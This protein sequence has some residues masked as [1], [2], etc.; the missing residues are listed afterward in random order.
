MISTVSAQ[1]S[2][3]LLPHDPETDFGIHQNV[4]NTGA[5]VCKVPFQ[6]N[7]VTLSVMVWDGENPGLGWD[8][9][10][11]S[12]TGSLDLD[13][14]NNIHDPDVVVYDGDV[15]TLAHV[16]YELN[17]HIY[18]E[19]WQ[20]DIASNSWSSFQSAT[21]LSTH[22]ISL[23]PNIDRISK[24]I[25]VVWTHND[26]HI[27][28]VTGD[29]MGNYNNPD[30]IY[31]DS[32]GRCIEPD[33]A[34]NWGDQ[35]YANKYISVV[36]KIVDG[37]ETKLRVG[38]YEFNYF[39]YNYVS[40]DL[41]GQQLKQYSEE[42]DPDIKFGTPRIAAHW[43][44]NQYNSDYPYQVVMVENEDN[45]NFIVH[46]FNNWDGTP[47]HSYLNDHAYE[48]ELDGGNYNPM[49]FQTKEPVVAFRSGEEI[50]VAWAYHAPETE[51]W[52]I[53]YRLLHQ[54]TGE[55][56]ETNVQGFPYSYSLVNGKD[57]YGWDD[58][59]QHHPCVASRFS[60]NEKIIGWFDNGTD[61]PEYKI[62]SQ[63]TIIFGVEEE[64]D[65]GIIY[66]NP[67]TK[68]L[69]IQLPD[70]KDDARIAIYSINGEQ[71]ISE[72]INGNL[73]TIDISGI[74]S[75][76]YIAEIKLKEKTIQKKFIKQ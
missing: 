27:R 29:M 21:Q 62:R 70:D 5:G 54:S 68:W 12:K 30:D 9:D 42:N 46:G 33:V 69:N 47:Q 56:I 63:S 52:E 55:V 60:V 3:F 11:G 17:D 74:N 76:M 15:G 16:V 2:A 72:K 22:T 38:K 53:M 34:L 43:G 37:T 49:E 64:G 14:G 61:M 6:G 25:A 45:T 8:L 75:G 31:Y 19:I 50:N 7:N 51:N 26:E 41:D 39:N 32:N 24:N 18:Y 13:G 73:N 23:N 71:I 44:D 48:S 4:E 35:N 28:G 40:L 65:P 66:P 58:A 20:Y 57:N 10:F 67:A 1:N 36:F 59:N